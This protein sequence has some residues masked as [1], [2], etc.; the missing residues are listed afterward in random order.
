MKKH[1]FVFILSFLAA[2]TLSN[3]GRDAAASSLIDVFKGQLKNEDLSDVNDMIIKSD[4]S[5]PAI[6]ETGWPPVEIFSFESGGEEYTDYLFDDFS[7]VNRFMFIKAG[8]YT[9]LWYVGDVTSFHWVSSSKYALS[10]AR[11]P[12]PPV[13]EPATVLLFGAGTSIFLAYQWR[14]KR[15]KLDH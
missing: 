2:V 9:D 12:I 7:N 4:P 15:K 11:V 13:P 5:L 3:I 8:R 1:I 10:K 14:R 6:P